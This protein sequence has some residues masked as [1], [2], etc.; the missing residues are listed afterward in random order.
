MRIEKRITIAHPI[1]ANSN[2][3]L[4]RAFTCSIWLRASYDCSRRSEAIK[5]CGII[6]P[7]RIAEVGRIA[8]ECVSNDWKPHRICETCARFDH[9]CRSKR[10]FGSGFGS[11]WY[12]AGMS[13]SD[14]LQR[15]CNSL[16]LIGRRS[17]LRHLLSRFAVFFGFV[18]KSLMDLKQ[19]QVLAREKT[20]GLTIW[21]PF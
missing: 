3:R 18:Q 19:V 1:V 5:A 4:A 12:P 2:A 16:V 10:S 21:D 13:N 14:R 15:S 17:G 9:N 11:K 8:G 20:D 7:L 6:R